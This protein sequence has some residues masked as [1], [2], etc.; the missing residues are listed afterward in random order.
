MDY[1]WSILYMVL[2]AKR[3]LFLKNVQMCHQNSFSLFLRNFFFFRYRRIKKYSVFQN[4]ALLTHF[5][6]QRLFEN[7][8]EWKNILQFVLSSL[9]WRTFYNK[10][11]FL[12][13]GNT[14]T[15]KFCTCARDSYPRL[16]K[17]FWVNSTSFICVWLVEWWIGK[18]LHPPIA[19]CAVLYVF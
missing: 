12:H 18:K 7:V 10:D 17:K 4:I 8:V 14:H 15:T 1:I 6:H 5:L 13:F 16:Y 9:F 3:L 11:F 2:R 19:R